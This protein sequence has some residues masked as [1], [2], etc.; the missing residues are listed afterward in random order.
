MYDVFRSPDWNTEG[1][2]WPLREHSRCISA[3]G[4][5]WHV[6]HFGT[7]APLLLI[8]GTAA[9]THSWA[10]IAPLL[11][12]YFEVLSVDLPGHGFSSILKRSATIENMTGAITALLE[13]LGVDPEI[14]IGHSAGAAIGVKLALARPGVRLLVGVSPALAPFSGAAG[15]AF[16][17][18][19]KLIHLNPAAAP[20]FAFAAGDRS[21]V[22]RL[23]A[24]TGSK[25]E[26]EGVDLY[27]RLPRCPGHVRGALAMMAA[28]DLS[29]MPGDLQ[30]LQCK[31]LFVIGANDKA[32]PPESIGKAVA[33]A[34]HAEC[35]VAEGIGHLA[36]E[37]K[38]EVVAEKV[39][40]MARVKE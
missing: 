26:A 23:I 40:E 19:A 16:P 25:I 20:A 27:A 14:V 29:S 32:T 6:Q 35:W 5:R 37:E 21:R 11:A 17:L 38:P 15:F 8:H 34:P 18:M 36:H 39:I 12:K 1:K 33:Y 30:S 9:S 7:G 2:D 24:Q 3:G 28:W 22:E 31:A 13:T 10:R 4:V